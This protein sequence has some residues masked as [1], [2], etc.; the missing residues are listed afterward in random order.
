MMA[1]AQL[2]ASR[3]IAGLR[4][5]RH[6]RPFW[7]GVLVL[8]AALIIGY[9]PFGPTDELIRAGSSAAAGLSAAVVLGV[10]GLVILVFPAQRILA[11]LAAVAVSLAA[12]VLSNLGGFVIGMLLG[13]LGGSLAVGWVPDKRAPDKRAPDKGVDALG[14]SGDASE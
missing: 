3:P 1:L 7:G 5:F 2:R 4:R 6:T 11:G 8:A 9:L 10:L 13:I 12:F 14:G